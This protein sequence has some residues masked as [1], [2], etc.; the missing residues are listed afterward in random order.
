MMRNTVKHI[1]LMLASAR[2]KLAVA[3]QRQESERVL[4]FRPRPL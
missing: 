2:E 4:L 3:E 1:E